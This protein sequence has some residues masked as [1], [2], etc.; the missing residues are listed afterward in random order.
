MNDNL[1][2]CGGGNLKALDA[3]GTFGGYA[4]TFGT[5][6]DADNVG[7]FF[8][9]KTDYWLEGKSALPA[10]YGHGLDGVMKNRRL[11]YASFKTDETGIWAQGQ[12]DLHDAWLKKVFELIKQGVL[13]WSSAAVAH[14]TSRQERLNSKGKKVFELENWPIGE[15]S[16]VP[17][18][19]DARNSI[20]ELKFLELPSLRETIRR[21]KMSES[22]LLREKSAQLADQANAI[23]DPNRVSPSVWSQR[24]IE[25]RSRY[26]GNEGERQTVKLTAAQARVHLKRAEDLSKEYEQ[27]IGAHKTKVQ[28]RA[29]YINELWSQYA[30]YKYA[31]MEV[32]R[33]M[34]LYDAHQRRM[35]Q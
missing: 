11:G 34:K 24:Q 1:L 12:I 15:V 21:S 29:K 13:S 14:L 35:N 16:L 18:P 10:V 5:P 2:V 28:R 17:N 6:D 7:D 25:T 27:L 33:A 23:L 32:G 30:G 20:R 26:L 3:E 22:D 8:T 9:A 19:A 4:V 31:G